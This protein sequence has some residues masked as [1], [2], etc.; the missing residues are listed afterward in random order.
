MNAIILRSALLACFIASLALAD[1]TKLD[2]RNGVPADAYLAVYAQHNPERDYQ[3]AYAK[4]IWQAIQDERLPQ[5]IVG[6]VLDQLPSKEQETVTSVSDE[7]QTIF[8]PVDWSAVADSRQFAYGQV[9]EV[10]QTHHLALVRL[11]SADVAASF[12][13]ALKKMGEMVERRSDGA[14]EAAVDEDDEFRLYTL[15]FS[16]I[17]EFPFQPAFA[18]INDVLVLST[19]EK[20]ARQAVKSLV[21]GGT[22]KFDDPRLKAALAKLPKPEDALVFYDGRQQFQQLRQIGQ[23]IHEK[24][25]GKP[26]ATRWARQMELII[27]QMAI[28]DYEVTVEYTDGYK[29]IKT[30]LGQL[31]PDAKEKLLYRVCASGKPFEDWQR[32][33][34]ADATAYSLSTG[35]NLHI[36]YEWLIQYVHDNIPE[37]QPKLDKLDEVQTEWG[38]HL[39]RDILQAFSGECV[40]VT[41][42]VS[43]PTSFGGHAN[44]VALRCEKPERIRELLHQGVE[45]LSKNPFAQA[46]QVKLTPSDE[47]KGFDRFSAGILTAF[48]VRPV[49]GFHDGWM[50]VASSAPAAQRVLQTLSGEAPSIESTEQFERFGMVIEGPVYAISYTDLAASTR[51]VAQV[52]R[53]L[54]VAVPMAVGTAAAAAKVDPEKLKPLQQA[55][56]LLPSIANVV[57]KFDFLEARLTVVQKGEAD[58]SYKKR[59][60]ILVRPP[61]DD[62]P[63]TPDTASN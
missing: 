53:Q 9:M 3:Q 34:P 56:A 43:S 11:P 13:R 35:A 46:Q 60:V 24:S 55:L 25:K 21:N 33:V 39:D 40:S 48:G 38:V 19:S 22:S 62:S 32:W 47:L 18:R 26:E 4:Q 41:I 52:I 2:I 50:I 7:L 17:K 44:V 28:L 29:N 6:L 20:V 8:E 57:E 15:T 59:S 5:R 42:P 1:E 58:G 30:S 27:D 49:I 10:P 14:V 45:S 37:A 54:G 63:D 12:E 31:V 36:L 23:F 51:Q 61:N 16:K